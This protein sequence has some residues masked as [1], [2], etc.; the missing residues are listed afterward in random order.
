VADRKNTTNHQS[1]IQTTVSPGRYRPGGCS[2]FSNQAKGL[3]FPLS[4]ANCLHLCNLPASCELDRFLL[5][6]RQGRDVIAYERPRCANIRHS[7]VRQSKEKAAR[8]RRKFKADEIRTKKANPRRCDPT[9]VNMW[10]KSGER[11]YAR[12]L[13]KDHAFKW[14]PKAQIIQDDFVG[15][16]TASAV[17]IKRNTVPVAKLRALIS[18]VVRRESPSPEA[19]LNG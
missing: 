18:L 1:V 13:P 16:S 8:R 12:W 19:I 2:F 15:S 3:L 7:L 10:M 17:P 4:A 11:S 5:I 9:G 14:K 6:P